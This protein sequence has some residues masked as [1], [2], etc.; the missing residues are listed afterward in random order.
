MPRTEAQNEAIRAES[1]ARIIAAALRLFA[2]HGYEATSVRQIAEEAGVAQGLL[3][4]YYASKEQLLVAIFERSVTDVRESFARAEAEGGPGERI[5]RLL[6]ASFDLLGQ[7]MEFWRLS[8]HVRMQIGVISGLVEHIQ[9]WT[10]TIRGKLEQ[11][12]SEAGYPQPAIEATILFALIDGVSQH[13]VLA[14]TTYPLTDVVE[15][16]VSRYTT[17]GGSAL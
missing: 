15:A 17:Q 4:N 8:Y 2:R 1:R 11:Y 14:P 3:Y 10:E 6:R 13:Y 12:L 9:P 5:E 7:N 16:L